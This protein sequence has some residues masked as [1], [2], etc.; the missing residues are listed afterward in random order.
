MPGY[1]CYLVPSPLL[2]SLTSTLISYSTSWFARHLRARW[3]CWLCCSRRLQPCLLLSE[4]KTHPPRPN[5]N[6]TSMSMERSTSPPSVI[7]HTNWLATLT[8][9]VAIST[10]SDPSLSSAAPVCAIPTL[11][12][13][14]TS[15][16]PAT[17]GSRRPT[18]AR[19]SRPTSTSPSTSRGTSPRPLTWTLLSPSLPLGLADTTTTATSLSVARTPLPLLRSMSTSV[20]G[21]TPRVTSESWAQRRSTAAWASA[22]QPRTASASRGSVATA[23]VP[24]TSKAESPLVR[25]IPMSTLL[26][27][28][29]SPRLRRPLRSFRPLPSS[30]P[31]R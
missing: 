31:P 12:A 11:T 4:Q 1:L 22:T 8:T 17:A 20:D 21:I 13:S 24:A 15:T 27:R 9:T 10:T 2:S 19:K 25:P 14:D 28:T 26:P 18:P 23:R 16:L 6:K 30:L 29:L 3:A 5:A 7:P